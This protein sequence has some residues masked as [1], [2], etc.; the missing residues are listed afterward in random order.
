[1]VENIRNSKG[2]ERETERDG[3]R[4]REYY[5]VTVQSSKFYQK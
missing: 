2:R 5:L 4:R 3:E 1:M